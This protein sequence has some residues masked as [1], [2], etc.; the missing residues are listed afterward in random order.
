VPRLPWYEEIDAQTFKEWGVDYLKYN[1]CYTDKSDHEPVRYER[2]SK[3]IA[4]T[5][6]DIHYSICIWGHGEPWKCA[7]NV[8]DSWRMSEDIGDMFNF[9]TEEERQF[10]PCDGIYYPKVISSNSEYLWSWP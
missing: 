6:W 10:C 5:N 8:S 2:M 3:A 7:S 4:K 9:S 1:L